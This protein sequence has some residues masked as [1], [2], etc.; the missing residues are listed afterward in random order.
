V[1]SPRNAG[2][3]DVA[4]VADIAARGFY[5]DP[6]MTWMFRDDHLRLDQLGFVF[7]GLAEGFL[8]DGVIH[9]LEDA[10]TSLWRSPGFDHSQRLPGRTKP[11]SEEENPVAATFTEDIQERF[12][13]LRAALGAAHPHQPHWYLNVLSTVPERQSQGLGARTLDPVLAICDS[14]RIP[15]YLESSNPRNIPFYERQGFVLTG[16]IPL[17]DGPCLYPMWRNPR[18]GRR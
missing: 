4:V 7:A 5:D 16:E 12:G 13:I 10:C 15:A 9:L 6:V 3:D 18:G 11:M 8:L 2:A 17:P 1:T 14:E